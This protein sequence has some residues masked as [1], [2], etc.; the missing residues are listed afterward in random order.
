MIDVEHLR[1]QQQEI[2]RRE[3]K[4]LD[5]DGWVRFYRFKG[6]GLQLDGDFTMKDLRMLLR[7]AEQ[8]WPE[9]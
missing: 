8:V 1:P 9:L 5:N 7:V 3:L 6:D 4:P 2:A